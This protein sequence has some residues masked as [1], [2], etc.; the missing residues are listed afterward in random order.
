LISPNL[1]PAGVVGFKPVRDFQQLPDSGI[2]AGKGALFREFHR[3]R[4]MVIAFQHVK[5]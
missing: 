5:S 4:R 1:K 3:T 2:D